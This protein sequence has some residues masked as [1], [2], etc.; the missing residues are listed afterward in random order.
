MSNATS[1]EQ[2]LDLKYK[3]YSTMNSNTGLSGAQGPPPG[4]MPT[5]A[6]KPVA[7]GMLPNN[8]QFLYAANQ[9]LRTSME[10]QISNG[11]LV[12]SEN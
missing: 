11:K 1:I 4:S 3:A 5:S 10:K 6:T 12:A 9:N 8:S 7:S 2:Q